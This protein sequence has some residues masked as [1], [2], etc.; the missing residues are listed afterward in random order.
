[1]QVS[2]PLAREE[3]AY[4]A[5]TLRGR[6]AHLPWRAA[7]EKNALLAQRP[8]WGATRYFVKAITLE[9]T[10]VVYLRNLSII[11]DNFLESLALR[12]MDQANGNPHEKKPE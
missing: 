4:P 12:A 9:A 1:V 8:L 7:P 5:G 11:D 6:R 2:N 10:T 3:T